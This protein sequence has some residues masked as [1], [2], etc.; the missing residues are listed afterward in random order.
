MHDFGDDECRYT[1]CVQV[2][3]CGKVI[4]IAPTGSKRLH[5]C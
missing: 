5:G 4:E 3:V 2:V 1:V